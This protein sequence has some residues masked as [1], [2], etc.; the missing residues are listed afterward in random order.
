MRGGGTGFVVEADAEVDAFESR[1]AEV[2]ARPGVGGGC[3]GARG[4]VGGGARLVEFDLM[5]SQAS[6]L[7]LRA[8]GSSLVVE[9]AERGTLFAKLS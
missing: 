3:G 2:G 4:G 8:W 1:V 9:R 6:A 7:L 5:F